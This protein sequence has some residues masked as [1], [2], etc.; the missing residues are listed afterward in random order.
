MSTKKLVSYLFQRCCI[1]RPFS[2]AS[3][4]NFQR[5][6]SLKLCKK[7][8]IHKFKKN[9]KQPL[10]MEKENS[11][12]LSK[13]LWFLYRE[14]LPMWWR[15]CCSSPAPFYQRK[16]YPQQKNLINRQLEI[17]KSSPS[18]LGNARIKATCLILLHIKSNTWSSH[19]EQEYIWEGWGLEWS[20]CF[21]YHL[22]AKKKCL[23][24]SLQHL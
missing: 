7:K 15:F 14:E 20:V 13:M 22:T 18:K 1:K 2:K 21:P 9:P 24:P 6:W 10:T 11:D 19:N 17:W 5:P 8:R 16:L 4:W 3:R 12:I 23:Q